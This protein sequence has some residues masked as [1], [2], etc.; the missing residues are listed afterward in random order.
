M[1]S[2]M[3]VCTDISRCRDS[4]TLRKSAIDDIMAV[5]GRSRSLLLRQRRGLRA[6]LN[7]LVEAVY[8]RDSPSSPVT[9][10]RG[11]LWRSCR[12]WR[13]LIP[14]PRRTRDVDQSPVHD[15]I[16]EVGALAGVERGVA[17]VPDQALQ[18]L[19]AP[20]GERRLHQGLAAEMDRRP[21]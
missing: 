16:G 18:P 9:C 21:R 7:Q 5:R 6:L 19:G 8:E 4:L 1:A 15:R 11:I 12:H 13:E 14:P 2:R 17:E 20:G 10:T 3:L